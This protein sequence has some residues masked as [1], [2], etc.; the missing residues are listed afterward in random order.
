MR[1]GATG[2][3]AATT[4]ASS[5]GPVRRVLIVG[6]GAPTVAYLPALLLALRQAGETEVRAVLTRQAR[7]MVSPAVVSAASGHPVIPEDWPADGTVAHMRWAGWPDV[8]VV[9]PATLEFLARCAFGLASDV[10][11][12]TVLSTAA[13]VV[14]APSLAP[15]A[16]QGGPYRRARSLLRR[17]GHTVIDPVVGTSLSDLRPSDGACVS[18]EHV[19]AEIQ[20]VHRSPQAPPD[21]SGQG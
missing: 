9:W 17:D 12:A 3:G 5:H 6:T 20:R 8:V 10:P 13:P 11:A 19:V 21:G 15:A 14:F 7:T 2:R 16:V 18:V 1:S 4:D